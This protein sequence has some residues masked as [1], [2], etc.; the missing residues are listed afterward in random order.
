MSKKKTRNVL[1]LLLALI[2]VC[3]FIGVLMSTASAAAQEDNSWQIVSGGYE[4]NTAAN[5]T[6]NDEVRIQKNVKPT[7][8]ENEFEVYLAVDA[9]CSETKT[10][11]AMTATLNDE[12]LLNSLY[13]GGSGNGFPDCYSG[14]EHTGNG[15][16]ADGLKGSPKNCE[17]GNTRFLLD[18]T[19]E[20][21]GQKVYTTDVI[22]DRIEFLG[23][24]KNGENNGQADT[25]TPFDEPGDSIPAGFAKLTD[26]DIPF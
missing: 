8:V 5:K 26:D 21:D 14:Q 25:T 13:T 24:G 12:S 23:S 3:A 7:A 17:P 2:V 10:S 22:A 16:L 6:G 15:A 18:I 20:K 19:Y 11:T 9:L 4:G 1:P